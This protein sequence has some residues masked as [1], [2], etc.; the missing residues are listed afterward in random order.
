MF[1]VCL[2]CCNFKLIIQTRQITQTLHL[3]AFKRTI[4]M[5]QRLKI[6]EV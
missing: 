4:L 5:L 3:K 2:Y 1:Q 6:K